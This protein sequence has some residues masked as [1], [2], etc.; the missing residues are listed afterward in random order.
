MVPRRSRP[1]VPDGPVVR[2][3]P[4]AALGHAAP[5]EPNVSDTVYDL[6]VVETE[7]VAL[8]KAAQVPATAAQARS[9]VGLQRHYIDGEPSPR[10]STARRFEALNPSTNEVL[11]EVAD[12]GRREIDAAVAAARRAFDEG[13]WPRLSAAQR[14]TALR[15]IAALLREHA[16]EFIEAEVLDIG[17]PITQMG[18]LAARA[19]ANFDYYAG[20]VSEL[21]WTRVPGRRRVPQL[22]DS[23]AG[24]RRRADH[25]VERAADALDVA[26]RAGA[27]RRQH[28]RAQASR[29]V[30][31]DRDA[32][33]ARARAGGAADRRLQRRARLRRDRRCAA[34]RRTRT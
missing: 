6:P 16:Q 17:L 5:S 3:L 26:H 33:G 15:R 11:A 18:G 31:A 2:T 14:A 4:V 1:R 7:E 32:A 9:A 21:S 10:A 28:D 30:A 19:A 12:G 23:Q 13:P 25:A 27:R 20:V 34:V 22:H 24:R 8:V 29:V